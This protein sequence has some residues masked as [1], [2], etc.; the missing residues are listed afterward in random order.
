MR[1]RTASLIGSCVL[2]L[3]APAAVQAQ[4]QEQV[5]NQLDAANGIMNESGFTL[6]RSYLT[7]SLNDDTSERV[8]L[9]LQA[10]IG[11]QIWGFCDND[12]SDLDLT[13]YDPGGNVVATDVELD[14]TPLLI[15][16]ASMSGSYSL[17]VKMIDCSVSPCFYGVGLWSSG[18]GGGGGGTGGTGTTQTFSGRLEKGDDTLETGEYFDAHSI[19]VQSGQ[20]VIVDMRSSDF[21]TYVGLGPPSDETI[22]NDDY[23]GD[24]HRSRVEVDATESGTWIIIA[25]SYEA[26]ETGAYT[27]TVTISGGSAGK[28]GA[29]QAGGQTYTG[30][31]ESGDTTLTSGEYYDS[32]TF[33]AS[34][35]QHL[36]VQMQS[37]DFDTYLGVRSPTGE[38]YDN[39]D[40]EGSTS[41]SQVEIDLAE[42]GTWTI[43]AT[44]YSE[45]MT[46]AYTVT[47]SLSGAGGGGSEGDRFE[48]GTLAGG[49]QTLS[50]GE[51]VDKYTYSGRQ[52]ETVT[53]DLRSTA[54]DPYLIV[55]S[56][57]GDQNDNDDFEGSRTRSLL[58]LTLEE[59]G[60][61]DVWVTS[62]EP[63]ETG[64]YDLRITRAG[65]GGG[66]GG[67]GFGDRTERGSLA[68]GD[69]TLET[70]EYADIISFEGAPGRHVQVDLTSSA[71]D[72]YLIVAGPGEDRGENDDHEGSTSQSRVELDMTETGTYRAVV[73]SYAAGETGDYELS[74]TYGGRGDDER[75]DV[76]RIS[77]GGSASGSLSSGDATLDSGEYR[78]LIAFDGQAGQSVAV[79][80]T[81]SDFDTYLALLTPDD[82]T[83]QNDDYEGSTSRSR[84][85][86]TLPS[87]GRYVIIATSYAAG[88]TG[89][90][91]VSLSSSA[92]PAPGPAPGPSGGGNVYG[93]F[94][95]ISDYPGSGSDLPYCAEDASNLA[96]AMTR[97][98][99]M[100]TANSILLTDSQATTGNFRNALDTMAGRVGPD[101]V[102]VIFY[103]GHGSRVDRSGGYEQAD[104]DGKDETLYLYDGHLFDNEMSE[105]LDTVNAGTTLLVL[106]A[107]FSGGFAKDVI[108]RPGRMGLFSS[109]E[110][111]T[112]MVAG[113]FTAGGY[114]A[115]FIAEA[116]GEKLADE[117]Q[118]GE[119]TALELSQYIYERYRTDVKS[120][121]AEDYVSLSARQLGYQHLVVDRGSI[122]PFQV[123]FR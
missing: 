11:Y 112:S 106:D 14:D 61:W 59:S 15:I 117:D 64:A 8:A 76:S 103:S 36:I 83:L 79:D 99:G 51:Y 110:D 9:D 54:F 47:Y 62:Y 56:P 46:G 29:E 88:E 114:L 66:S 41:R 105:L 40:H 2:L 24:T 97:G 35:G 87:S 122:G 33:T 113:K 90:Y 58:S 39:D 89:T 91:Q 37:G 10:G 60:E 120:G 96:A 101:D 53:F 107:C 49:D 1:I 119:I 16:T 95:G 92:G 111:V 43:L 52:G 7:G 109:E 4:Y 73:T 74:I 123:I 115:Y 84:I 32:F 28:P 50:S 42:S 82:E 17:E 70:G 23:E 20:H 48:A 80:M 21:D 38:K 67:T 81:S 71:F 31:L 68:A 26:G 121:G 57:S 27:V 104:P 78:D 12:C 13:L 3:T 44:S 25:T 94:M 85:E 34:A 69:Q 6:V 65:A 98:V 30:R 102:L 45:G 63:G 100:S 18:G 19:E 86:L 77:M 116:V 72:T 108:S 5:T 75:Y 118:N 22:E 55:R 93:I